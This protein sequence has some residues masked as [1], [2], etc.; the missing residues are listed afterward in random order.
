MGTR[1]LLVHA[2]GGDSPVAVGLN[3]E[4]LH[5]YDGVDEDFSEIMDIESFE[6]VLFE[7]EVG[8]FGVKQILHFLVVNLEEGD[9]D[10][11]ER[12]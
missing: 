1:A 6:F 12:G 7:L 11:E 2:G 8:L 10:G 3:D 9:G 4:L 5:L